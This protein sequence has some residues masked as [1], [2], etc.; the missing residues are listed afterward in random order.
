[1]ILSDIYVPALDRANCFKCPLEDFLN[2][3]I[4]FLTL[5]KEL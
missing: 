5:S 4:L 3:T 2:M 1:M